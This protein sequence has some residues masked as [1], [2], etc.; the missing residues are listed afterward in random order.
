MQAPRVDLVTLYPG[1]EE[2]ERKAN[3]AYL[4]DGVSGSCIYVGLPDPLEEEI[5]RTY[6][7]SNQCVASVE[8]YSNGAVNM[9]IRL[10]SAKDIQNKAMALVRVRP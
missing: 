6:T 3:R 10:R 2:W 1:D 7:Y 4:A 5:A 9:F 8:R